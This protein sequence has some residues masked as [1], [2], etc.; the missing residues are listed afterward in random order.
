MSGSPVLDT[1]GRLIGI[2]AAA[3]GDSINQEAT[4]EK[5]EL[6]L[7]YSWHPDPHLFASAAGKDG[8]EIERRVFCHRD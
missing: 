4:G 6:Q 2:H 1:G 8:A 3:E 5:R 7:G